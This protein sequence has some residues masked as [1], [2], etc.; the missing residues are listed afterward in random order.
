MKI[1]LMIAFIIMMP[2]IL[3]E[4]GIHIVLKNTWAFNMWQDRS[5]EAYNLDI[6]DRWKSNKYI[7]KCKQ[8]EQ[9]CHVN[10]MQ[11]PYFLCFW[12][13]N[14]FFAVFVGR[15]LA[16]KH[17]SKN[18]YELISPDLDNPCSTV[19]KFLP[20]VL[21]DNILWSSKNKQN[22][23]QIII[24]LLIC[25]YSLGHHNSRSQVSQWI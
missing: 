9:N 12:L 7:L 25:M 17:G 6:Q 14:F 24:N 19:P 10:A 3:V 23:N 11:F 22:S 5:K 1:F 13:F 18:R 16:E 15:L 20:T 8:T 2:K 4:T 21:F